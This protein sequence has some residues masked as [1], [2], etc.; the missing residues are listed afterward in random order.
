LSGKRVMIAFLAFVAVFAAALVYF[1]FFAFYQRTEAPEALFVGDDRV[2]VGA[3]EGIDATTSPL[4]LR[5][6]FETEVAALAEA[7]PVTDATPLTPPFW[8]RCFDARALTQDLEAGRAEAFAVARD[9]PD[10]FDTML[11]VYP[12]GRAYLWRQLNE[13]FR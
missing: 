5:A 11:A 6:C 12:D 4:K 8:F 10:G 7:E 2:P 9:Q 13:R 1:Q 3:W